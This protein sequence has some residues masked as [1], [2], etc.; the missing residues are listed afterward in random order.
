MPKILMHVKHGCKIVVWQMPVGH[1]TPELAGVAVA[2][3][4]RKLH[5]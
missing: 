5:E 3:D 2:T 1:G 4:N